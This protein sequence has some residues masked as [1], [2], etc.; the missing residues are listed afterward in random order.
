[1]PEKKIPLACEP[2]PLALPD[3]LPDVT[4][5]ADPL[6]C[7]MVMEVIAI[8]SPLNAL[9]KSTSEKGDW[10]NSPLMVMVT[11]RNLALS[12]SIKLSCSP[13]IGTASPSSKKTVSYSVTAAL[14]S[15]SIGT[16]FT[17]ITLI[18]ICT[19]LLLYSLVL[20]AAA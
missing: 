1:M 18:K 5:M 17:E 15:R 19:V 7:A 11:S 4:P 14:E 13:T 8:M 3:A 12:L 2:L 9:P 10:S 16:S 6:D 20:D